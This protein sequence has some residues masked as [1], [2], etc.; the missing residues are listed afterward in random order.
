[1][2]SYKSPFIRPTPENPSPFLEPKL[3][4]NLAVGMPRVPTFLHS[5]GVT[6]NEATYLKSILDIFRLGRAKFSRPNGGLWTLSHDE[7]QYVYDISGNVLPLLST[8]QIFNRSWLHETIWFLSGSTDIE[9]LKTHGVSIWDSW[10][11]AGT[12][13]WESAA[14]Y[15]YSEMVNWVRLKAGQKVLDDWFE[16]NRLHPSDVSPEQAMLTWWEV[17]EGFGFGPGP[18]PKVKLV[19]GSIGNGAYGSQWR[20]WRDVRHEDY[21]VWNSGKTALEKRGFVYESMSS[22]G[23]EEYSDEGVVFSRTIDQMATVIKQLKSDPDGRRIIVTAW[24]PALIDEAALPPCHTLFQFIS[25]PSDRFNG[26][27]ELTVKLTQ[28]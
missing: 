13:R 22:T 1:M 21:D 14:E 15:R 28:R 6:Q 4:R 17:K 2:S 8:K 5:G 24:N 16:H 9:Y 20:K 23:P 3:L 11:I 10:V 25:Y 26:K 12:D 18:I 19:G 7:G 27:R